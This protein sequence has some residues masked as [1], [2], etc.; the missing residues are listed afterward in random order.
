MSTTRISLCN[1]HAPPGKVPQKWIKNE[2]AAAVHSRC[3]PG[4]FSLLNRL[5]SCSNPDTEMRQKLSD[6]AQVHVRLK[7]TNKVLRRG[8]AGFPGFLG[9]FVRKTPQTS[10]DCTRH[11]C[12]AFR[13]KPLDRVPLPWESPDSVCGKHTTW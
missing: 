2:N 5:S 10:H 11:V 1:K 4:R 9:V 7:E 3:C 13:P 8:V 6:F 12:P